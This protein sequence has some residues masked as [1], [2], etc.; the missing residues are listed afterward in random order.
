MNIYYS[1]IT[2]KHRDIGELA[3]QVSQY[4]NDVVVLVDN[5]TIKKWL[6]GYLSSFCSARVFIVGDSYI[7]KC[8]C[9]IL[10]FNS[11]F[12]ESLQ[13]LVCLL[14]CDIIDAPEV[15]FCEDFR[16]RRDRYK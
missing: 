3:Q 15:A 5:E 6:D 7:K 1:V 13:S 12:K 16:V 8:D 9:L 10:A 2:E 4:Y 14:D 11:H